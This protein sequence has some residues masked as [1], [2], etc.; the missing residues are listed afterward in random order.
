MYYFIDIENSETETIEGCPRI[1]EEISDSCSDEEDATFSSDSDGRNTS[2]EENVIKNAL[3][4][5]Q[6]SSLSASEF[7]VIL[8]ALRQRHNIANIALDSI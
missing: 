7:N 4:L 3:P 6:D 5:F 2:D 1:E 8:L